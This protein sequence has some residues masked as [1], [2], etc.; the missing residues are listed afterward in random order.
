MSHNGAIEKT[1]LFEIDFLDWS[2]QKGL[3]LT[4]VNL[5][6]V[7]ICGKLIKAVTHQHIFTFK[8]NIPDRDAAQF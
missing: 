5:L 2:E 8:V 6:S 4:E 1:L 3:P 7:Q